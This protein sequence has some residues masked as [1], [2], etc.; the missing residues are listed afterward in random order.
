MMEG[1]VNNINYKKS[2]FQKDFRRVGI[3][4]VDVESYGKIVVVIFID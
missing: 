2:V 4:V 1:L 3:A